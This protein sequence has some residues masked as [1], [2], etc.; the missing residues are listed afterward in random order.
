MDFL[1]VYAKLAFREKRREGYDHL[2]LAELQDH[3]T[4]HFAKVRYYQS[5]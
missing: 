3:S 4:K 2:W 5:F 1:H